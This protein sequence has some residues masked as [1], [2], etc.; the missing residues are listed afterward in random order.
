[1]PLQIESTDEEIAMTREGL[2]IARQGSFFVGGRPVQAAGTYQADTALNPTGQRFWVDQMYVQY[3]LPSA[4]KA[5]PIV[6]VHGGGQT[7][8][9]WETTPDGREGFA[10]LMLRRGHPV[11]VVD[12]PGRGRSGINGA[13][14]LGLVGDTKVGPEQQL[15][16]GEQF[17]W[18]LFRLG[19]RFGEFF[20]GVQFAHEAVDSFMKQSISWPE[21]D[22]EVLSDALVQLFDRIG[23]GV[24]V[25]HSRSGYTGWATAM[26]SDNVKAVVSYE[27]VEFA[28]PERVPSGVVRSRPVPSV[29]FARLARVPIQVVYGDNLPKQPSQDRGLVIWY[30]A[31]QWAQMFVSD[32]ANVGGRAELRKLAEAGI[33]GNTH[34]PMSDLNNA[35]VADDLQA[36]LMRH[37]LVTP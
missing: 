24:L 14:Q 29:E 35:R 36:F 27:P 8:Q 2:P 37:G 6:M 16:V 18:T 25:T 15:R 23:P 21:E 12:L 13:Q 11:Y 32:L 22:P 9:T 17:A 20:P 30:L 5:L 1:L 4:P 34:F 33:S 19:P 28:F 31:P 10:S 7:G 26:K 3:Q